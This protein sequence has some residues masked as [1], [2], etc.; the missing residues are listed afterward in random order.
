MASTSATVNSSLNIPIFTILNCYFQHIKMRT[1]FI[2]HD[3][4][5][6]VENGFADLG[7]SEQATRL[8]EKQKKD[9]KALF[10]I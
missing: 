3:L 5:D 10:L 7:N 9:A 8:K 6:S 4:W 1:L 2:S